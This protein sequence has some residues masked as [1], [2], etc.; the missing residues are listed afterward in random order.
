MAVREIRVQRSH[1]EVDPQPF[2]QSYTVDVADQQTLLDALLLIADTL[3]PTLA[4][5][6]T[7]RSGICGACAASVNGRPCL[8]CQLSIGAAAGSRAG[9]IAVQPLP[10]FAV[11]R[12]LVVDME[13]FFEAFDRAEAWLELN[14]DY[15]GTMPA[16][17]ARSLWPAM[18]CV[19][20]GICAGAERR[21]AG[22]HPA[23]VSRVLTLAHDPRDA[24]G[25]SRRRVLATSPDRAFAEWLKAVCPKGVDVT[26]LVE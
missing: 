15:D 4:F 23:A 19:M 13:P 5:R 25:R 26:G 8:L 17:V 21:D 6:R 9:A 22:L 7:C 3:D 20:C 2:W 12:D 16:D 14:P 18:T 1:G 10:G 11:L 24:R